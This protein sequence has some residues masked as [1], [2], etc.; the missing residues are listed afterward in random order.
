M[1]NFDA[2]KDLGQ[3]KSVLE[4]LPKNPLQMLLQNQLNTVVEQLRNSVAK[5]DFDASGDLRKS[6]VTTKPNF[7]NGTLE[8]GVEANYYYKF[9]DQG[10]N[11]SKINRGAPKHEKEPKRDKSFKQHIDEWIKFRGIKPKGKIYKSSY[12]SLNFLIRRSIVENGKE[13]THFVAEVVN[14]KLI[15][16]MS[17]EI[18]NLVGRAIEVKITL[19]HG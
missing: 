2:I 15:N 12:K 9:L 4:N 1:D 8:I 11:G 16:N 18:S 6:F 19:E 17:Q 14:D 13:P 10:V 3:A 5:K 7:K